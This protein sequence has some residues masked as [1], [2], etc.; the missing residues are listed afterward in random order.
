[1]ML[2]CYGKGVVIG[3][4]WGVTMGISDRSRI[5]IEVK[6]SIKCSLGFRGIVFINT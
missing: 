4:I 2:K 3:K 6:R 5:D 1:M